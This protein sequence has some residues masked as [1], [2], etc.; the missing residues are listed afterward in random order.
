MC[1]ADTIK[2]S[3]LFDVVERY[4]ASQAKL[5]EVYV[6]MDWLCAD[7]HAP[8]THEETKRPSIQPFCHDITCVGRIARHW[9]RPLARRPS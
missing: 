2:V 4:A 3:D 9:K 7:K 5:E 6:H 1:Y 8:D